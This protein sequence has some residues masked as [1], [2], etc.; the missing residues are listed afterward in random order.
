MLIV[1][2]CFTLETLTEFELDKLNLRQND[3]Q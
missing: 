3:K 2:S 1:L